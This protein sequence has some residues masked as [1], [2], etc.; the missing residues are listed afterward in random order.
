MTLMISPVSKV[1]FCAQTYNVQDILSRPGAFT[2]P[3]EPVINEIAPPKHKFLKF[4][5]KTLIAVGVIAGALYGL[6]RGFPETFK[7]TTNFQ[8]LQ[9]TKKY[10]AYITTTVAKGA[11]YIEKL[12]QNCKAGFDNILK[13]VKI[14]K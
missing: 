1:N 2:R 3:A 4:V 8:E 6:K 13:L 14:K 7:I 11:E 9:G 10:K 12:G 5:A